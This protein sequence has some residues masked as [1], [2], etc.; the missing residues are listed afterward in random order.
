MLVTGIILL[1]LILLGFTRFGFC[2]SRAA[3]EKARL[4]L[5]AGPFRLDLLKLINRIKAK[6]KKKKP[7]K[8]KKLMIPSI[9]AKALP[10]AVT[11]VLRSL[12]KGIRIDRLTLRVTVA[13]EEDPCAAALTYG[14]L[15]MVWGFLRPMICE[16]LRIKK[17]RVEFGLDFDNSKTQWE[18][19]LT[20]TISLGRSIAV[21][22]TILGVFIKARKGAKV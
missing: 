6:P 16:N 3:G 4:V 21:F 11:P 12:R 22:C 13:G 15:H 10:G 19:D 7:E 5:R 2:V 20:V 9:P 8:E 18:G 17:Q 1:V 14:R